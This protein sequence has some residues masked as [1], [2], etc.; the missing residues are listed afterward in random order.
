MSVA[1]C[2][3]QPQPHQIHVHVGELVQGHRNGIHGCSLLR[4]D[5]GTFPLLAFLTPGVDICGAASPDKPAGQHTP[6]CTYTWV[7]QAVHTVENQAPHT[8]WYKRPHHTQGGVTPDL[9]AADVHIL[10]SQLD[11]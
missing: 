5:L 11:T 7:G 9:V 2:C 3:S 6:G 10:G 8:D 1:L 4:L